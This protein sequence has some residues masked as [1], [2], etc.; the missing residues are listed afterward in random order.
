MSDEL[1]DLVLIE[2]LVSSTVQLREGLVEL[3]SNRLRLT[4]V[5]KGGKQDRA[6]CYDD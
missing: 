6:E 3:V 1:P 2:T 5:D 4:F